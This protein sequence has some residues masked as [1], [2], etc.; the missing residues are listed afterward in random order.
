MRRIA[1]RSGFTMIELLVVIAISVILAAI[2]FPVFAQAREKA[3]QAGCLS[4]LK[5]I[6]AAMLMYAAD[7]DERFP[8]GPDA[9]WRLWVPGPQGSWNRMP[10]PCC[11]D[12]AQA[13]V[14]FQLMPYVK[15]VRTFLCPSDLVGDRQSD[16]GKEWNSDI[17]RSTYEA[18]MGLVRG[19]S[20][21]TFPKGQLLD[22]GTPVSLAEVRRPALLNIAGDNW[23]QNHSRRV[24]SEARWNVCY[25]DGHAKFTRWVND[26][27][28]PQQKQYTWN[29]FNPALPVDLEK[30]CVPDCAAEA[31]QE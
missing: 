27:L 14:A 30:P 8:G 24:P 25:A 16:G 19:W 20:W 6:G 7:Y 3:R 21:Q 15:S 5:Q 13:N 4:N 22:R 11:G 10:T 12:V 18:N 26:W 23:I 1:P 31:A 17:A 28:P 29:H 9:R 2:L